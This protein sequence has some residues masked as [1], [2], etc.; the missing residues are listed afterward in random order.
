MKKDGTGMVGD[1]RGGTTE[2]YVAAPPSTRRYRN[3]SSRRW[4]SQRYPRI[5]LSTRNPGRSQAHRP[6][7][8]GSG[9]RTLT[10]RRWIESGWQWQRFQSR[11]AHC[12]DMAE[13]HRLSAGTLL[14]HLPARITSHEVGC[15]IRHHTHHYSRACPPSGYAEVFSSIMMFPPDTEKSPDPRTPGLE[16]SSNLT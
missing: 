13:E 6:G 11:L 1:R 3:G 8:C 7:K 10:F 9:C 2:K 5:A 16:D 4:P 12:Y 14:R 15:P